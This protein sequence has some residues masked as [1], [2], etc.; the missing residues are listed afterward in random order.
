M[1]CV[2]GRDETEILGADHADLAPMANLAIWLRGPVKPLVVSRIVPSLW[3]RTI[4]AA[5]SFRARLMACHASALRA[6]D[7]HIILK[8]IHDDDDRFHLNL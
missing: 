3:R 6:P 4:T 8:I 1:R 2:V 7:R 5:R